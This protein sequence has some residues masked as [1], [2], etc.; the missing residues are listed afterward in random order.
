MCF[1]HS[2]WTLEIKLEYRKDWAFAKK[3]RT[4]QKQALNALD[5]NVNDF[6]VCKD[7]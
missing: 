7:E 2:F 6:T 3:V 5:A 4:A 1:I